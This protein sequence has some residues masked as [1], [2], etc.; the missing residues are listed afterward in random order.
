M[1]S[2][3]GMA[4]D[5]PWSLGARH[6]EA[7]LGIS[8]AATWRPRTIATVA[9]A[10]GYALAWLQRG[11]LL[12]P[13][14]APEL[15]WSS[16][17]VEAYAHDLLMR[18]R[19]ATVKSRVLSLERA[20]A[21]LAPKSNRGALRTVIL[22][23]EV[24]CDH[25]HKRNRLQDPDRLVTLGVGLMTKAEQGWHTNR[26]KNAATF[27][28]GLQIALLALRGFRKGK[29]ASIRIGTHLRQRNGD[30]WL[31][32]SR[33]ETKNHT[34][35]EVQSSVAKSSARSNSRPRT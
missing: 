6:H 7:A 20:L 2:D 8:V 17:R 28:D 35:L 19:P 5:R 27:R 33:Y 15:R 34:P 24:P 11:D 30:W 12:D 1:P 14:V 10:Y 13:T 25:G 18:L 3:C 29:F 32:F 4:T 26:R 31:A 22:S 16:E 9:E 21:V 23:L